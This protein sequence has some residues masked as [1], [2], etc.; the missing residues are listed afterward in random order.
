MLG[1]YNLR[2]NRGNQWV[3]IQSADG[4]VDVAVRRVDPDY[5]DF[6]DGVQVRVTLNT[7]KGA[8]RAYLV[9]G[10]R[11]N[12]DH[13]SPYGRLPSDICLLA[14]A[15]LARLVDGLDEAHLGDGV[16]SYEISFYNA[17][18]ALLTTLHHT[19]KVWRQVEGVIIGSYIAY[20]C[21]GDL[22][23]VINRNCVEMKVA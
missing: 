21:Y 20:E 11:V 19:Q 6:L 2:S 22:I 10:A 13:I 5:V 16:A 3:E 14:R 12:T 1:Q 4:R 9:K 18:G 8:R 7:E 15:D 17:N 23:Q